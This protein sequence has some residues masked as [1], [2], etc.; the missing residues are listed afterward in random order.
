MYN[1][2]PILQI[3][4][5]Y[6]EHIAMTLVLRR[7]L[8]GIAF[9]GAFL[10]AL[11]TTLAGM[12]NLATKSP[13]DTPSETATP[14]AAP[15]G[16]T[17]FLVEE[18]PLLDGE[19][20]TDPVWA[21]ADP[22]RD[23]WQ[24]RPDEGLPATERTEVRV[25]YTRDTLFFGIVCYDADPSGII[26]SDS[27][28]DSPLDDTDS[29]RLILDT[30]RDQ[31]NGFVFGTNPAAV[32]YDGQLTAEGQGGGFGGGRQRGGSGG[33]FNVNWDS[34]WE[35][36]TKVGDFGWSIEFA[37]PF[38]TLR[39]P[40][41]DRQVWGVNYQ[42][43]IRRRNE[44]AFWSPLSRQFNLFRLSSAG[45]IDGLEIPSQENFKVIPYALGTVRKRGDQDTNY[46]GDAGLD[47]KYSL[48]PS[49]TLDATYNTDFAQVEVDEQQINLDRFNL[50]F[51]EK[52]P[53]FLENAGVF[54]VGDSGEAELFFSRRI[55]IGP[56]GRPIP[57]LGGAR[58]SGKLART[59]IG[60]LN[61]QTESL[62]D[63]AESNNFT[64]ARVSRELPNRSSI[65]AI[66]VNRQGGGAGQDYNRTYGFDGRL[67]IGEFTEIS[68]FFAGSSTPGLRD[69]DLAFKI[70]AE[71]NAAAWQFSGNYTQLGSNFNPEV[72]FLAREGGYR[73]P[74]FLIF[75]RYRPDFGGFYEIRPHVSYRGY[76]T[77]D[78][79]Q[80]TG[81]L[82][83]DSHWEWR[84]GYEVHTG[85]NFTR[86]GVLEP[87]EIFPDVQV[88]KGTYDHKE[89]QI[90]ANTNE[91]DW[92]SFR[93]R[94][95][96]GGFFGG[97]RVAMTPGMRLR[98]GETFNMD[99]SWTR[100]DIDLPVGAFETN[101]ARWRVSYSFSPRVF[102]Q[103]LVQ[104]NDRSDIWSTNLRFAWLQS[105][106]TGLFVVYNDTRGLA[107]FDRTVLPD[108]SLIIKYNRLFDLL[109]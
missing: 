59:N 109:D 58:V 95:N 64:V 22:A 61:M 43:N 53:F 50:F 41:N 106:N 4:H 46:L 37:I 34:S 88:P 9:A 16:M 90:V 83:V 68:G 84:N 82:H 76:W 28:R 25:V 87:F 97:D 14:P 45:S 8:L 102:V 108:R 29:F 101:L 107:D 93:F 15:P 39:Y 20:L 30:Y 47:V 17:A 32:E 31:Q 57:I 51:P 79:F 49:L 12:Q 13:S 104:Y 77:L 63:I 38:R 89:G 99:L 55:G 85:I 72:G 94:T 69:D 40:S 91:A 98:F 5:R 56:G 1:M 70:G 35:V 44:V 54:S 92:L 24:T 66:F 65:G 100:N 80:Q 71:Y 23:F 21:V 75:H 62:G 60:F 78:G 3:G 33:G 48:T 11:P 52:R 7:N 18:A 67:G 27:R 2:R 103:A 19:V 6:P 36:R 81:F 96:F 105:A 42:R 86:E 10:C 74:D 73:K 26:V